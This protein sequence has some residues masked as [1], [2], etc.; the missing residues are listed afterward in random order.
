MAQPRPTKHGILMDYFFK[1]SFLSYFK[2]V[3]ARFNQNKY[4][5]Q[6]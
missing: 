1:T 5:N 6:S 2:F 3:L 4:G